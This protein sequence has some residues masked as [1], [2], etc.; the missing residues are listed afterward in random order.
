MKF[1]SVDVIISGMNFQLRKGVC[2][3][4]AIVNS[5]RCFGVRVSQKR[6]I[7]LAGTDEDTGTDEYGILSALTALGFSGTPYAGKT[8]TDALTWLTHALGSGPVIIC[9]NNWDHW[10]TV[11][12]K[13][14]DKYVVIDS[15][16][17]LHNKRENGVH[18]YSSRELVKKWFNTKE[19][20]LYAIAIAKRRST[21]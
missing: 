4:A 18:V 16:N 14:V 11:I 20:C 13:S 19:M 7:K 1:E 10:V 6:V 15:S 9:V 8:K 12:A 21:V 3:P 5:L 2:G 17:T